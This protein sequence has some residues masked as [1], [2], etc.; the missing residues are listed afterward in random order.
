MRHSFAFHRLPRGILASF[1]LLGGILGNALPLLAQI[2]T[3]IGFIPPDEHIGE[4]LSTGA[5]GSR[6]NCLKDPPDRPSLTVLAPA[7]PQ[8]SE[9]DI[10]RGGLTKAP[11]P[12]LFVYIPET[13]AKTADFLLL[14]HVENGTVRELHHREFALPNGAGIVR[15]AL[16][17]A[18]EEGQTYEWHFALICDPDDRN[19]DAIAAGT[20]QRIASVAPLAHSENGDPVAQIENYGKAGLWYDFFALLTAER[21]RSPQLQSVW[22]AALQQ[23]FGQNSPIPEAPFLSCCSLVAR[24]E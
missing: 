24:E 17:V 21:E 3:S 9:E 13:S 4:P 5:G 7:L 12:S 23:E 10:I 2:N 14:E 6:G 22:E 18:L 16:P 15:L 20:I 1:L 8:S 19:G 11:S